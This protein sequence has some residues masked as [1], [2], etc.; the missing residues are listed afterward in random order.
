MTPADVFVTALEIGKAA[1]TDP[2]LAALIAGQTPAA[3]SAAPL[4]AAHYAALTRIGNNLTQIVASPRFVTFGHQARGFREF[5]D[6]WRS[7]L[8]VEADRITATRTG[9][10]A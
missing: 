5:T 1:A 8:T 4:S 2:V 10:R 3:G 9:G 6:R 7:M